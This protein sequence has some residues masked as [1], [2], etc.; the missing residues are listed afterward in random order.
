[1]DVRWLDTS[2]LNVKRIEMERVRPITKKDQ[3]GTDD[4]VDAHKTDKD[5]RKHHPHD[6]GEHETVEETPVYEEHG[7]STGAD[8]A[9][10]HGEGHIF[11]ALA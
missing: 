7:I 8:S 11:D 1:M 10:N 2:A 5:G 9:D 6:D 3:S 4:R